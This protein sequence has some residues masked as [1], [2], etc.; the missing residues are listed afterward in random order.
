MAGRA[1][2]NKQTEDRLDLDKAREILD[3]DHYDLKR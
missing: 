3:A 2:W 1:A